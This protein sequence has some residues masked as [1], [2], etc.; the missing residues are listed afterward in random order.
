V[1]VISKRI[2]TAK[3]AHRCGDCGGTIRPGDRYT[4]MFGNAHDYDKPYEL[5]MCQA[6]RPI[7]A[8]GAKAAG[9][10]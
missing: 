2:R 3:R 4:R 10:A 9:V 7:E 5:K 1:P 6:C 8:A